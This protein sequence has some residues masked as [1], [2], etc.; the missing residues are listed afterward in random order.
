MTHEAL[1]ANFHGRIPLKYYIEQNLDLVLEGEELLHLVKQ[2][3]KKSP[4]TYQELWQ[5]ACDELWEKGYR[6]ERF[7]VQRTEDEARRRYWKRLSS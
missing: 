6:S 2:V 4:R 5:V 7:V 3:E 1:R